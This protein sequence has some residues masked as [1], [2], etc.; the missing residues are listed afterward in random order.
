MVMEILHKCQEPDT[1]QAILEAVLLGLYLVGR[2]TNTQFVVEQEK[3]KGITPKDQAKDVMAQKVLGPV[4]QILDAVDMLPIL[5]T[6]IPVINL[7]IPSLAKG[8]LGQSIG[9]LGDLLHNTPLIGTNVQAP[10]NGEKG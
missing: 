10:E 7:S 9:F 5:N 2:I 8:I 4:G 1:L 6:K 3:L